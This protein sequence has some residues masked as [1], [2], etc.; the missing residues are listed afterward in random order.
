[1]IKANNIPPE[2]LRSNTPKDMTDNLQTFVSIYNYKNPDIFSMIRESTPILN[3]SPEMDKAMKGIKLIS[4]RRRPEDLK[5][6]RTRAKFETNPITSNEPKI[7][8]CMD[9]RC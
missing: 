3:A 8:Q 9:P 7:F 6:I 4:C 1:M 2:T 5:R